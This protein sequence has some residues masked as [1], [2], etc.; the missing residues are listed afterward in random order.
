MATSRITHTVADG[1]LLPATTGREAFE[2]KNQGRWWRSFNLN[3]SPDRP[4][5]ETRI[6]VESM[7]EDRTLGEI[8][9][10]FEH[11]FLEFTP[12]QV[13]AF[14]RDYSSMLFI[15]VG[16]NTLFRLQGD[17]VAI[18]DFEDAFARPTAS[19]DNFSLDGMWYQRRGVIV[20][21]I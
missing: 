19:E 3:K 21:S 15:E 16:N 7:L 8:L 4:T 17:L 6:N 2:A 5:A 20:T 11:R 10:T 14:C 13:V 12:S 1:V 18:V 9:N